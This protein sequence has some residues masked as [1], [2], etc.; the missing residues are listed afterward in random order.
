M[1]NIPTT[2]SEV[3]AHETM[4]LY[5]LGY[6]WFS[7]V[8]IPLSEQT[9]RHTREQ[10]AQLFQIIA[11]IYQENSAYELAKIYY[12]QV[13]ELDETYHEAYYGL[14]YLYEIT[15]KYYAAIQA[16]DKLLEAYPDNQ[17]LLEDKSRMQENVIYD[18]PHFADL[19]NLLFV[20]YA[21]LALGESATVIELMI[22]M[23]DQEGD[24][25]LQLLLAAYGVQNEVSNYQSGWQHYCEQTEE[26]EI[27][28]TDW[29]YMPKQLYQSAVIWQILYNNRSK[30]VDFEPLEDIE[31]PNNC[32]LIEWVGIICKERM[33]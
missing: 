7:T 5:T 4:T 15:G 18:T 30:I 24:L 1:K 14:V 23:I 22:P 2:I 21:A 29:F 9:T 6:S 3:L 16:I 12:K 17:Q 11:E 19:K 26:I 8:L 25:F 10:Q 28:K 27:T 13:I 33:Q 31:Q 20:T 32:T